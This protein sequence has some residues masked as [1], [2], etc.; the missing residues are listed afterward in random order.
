MFSIIVPT[1]NEE[2]YLPK[3]LDSIQRQSLRP[4]EIIIADADSADK[5]REIARKYNCKIVQGG[6]ISVGRNNGAK[7]AKEDILVFID[8]DVILPSKNFFNNAIG[9]FIQKNADLATGLILPADKKFKYEIPMR[10]VNYIHILFHKLKKQVICPGTITICT[11]K[12]FNGLNGFDPNIRSCED[13]DFVKRAV[14]MRKRYILL[15]ESIRASTRRF[16][17]KGMK[18]LLF[19]GVLGLATILVGTKWIRKIRDKSEKDYW[20][21][22]I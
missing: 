12:T 21:N 8:A 10:G 20:D 3:L 9:T 4:S 13:R 17:R 7:V 14:K 19:V 18:G 2:K 11:K 16:E 22:L 15:P 5:T 6:R 1:L